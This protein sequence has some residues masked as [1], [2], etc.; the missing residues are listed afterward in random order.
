VEKA[1][2]G[3]DELLVAAVHLHG[4]KLLAQTWPS[5]V[6]VDEVVKAGSGSPLVKVT[7]K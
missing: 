6:A 3:G 4:P 5:L 7:S 1:I 2:H